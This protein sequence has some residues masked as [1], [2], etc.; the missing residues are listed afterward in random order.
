MVKKLRLKFLLASLVVFIAGGVNVQAESFNVKNDKSLRNAICNAKSND[1][2]I[3]DN[4]IT[5]KENLNIDKSVVLD[6]NQKTLVVSGDKSS[7]VIGKKEQKNKKERAMNILKLKFKEE[8]KFNYDDNI[9][10]VIKNGIISHS[11]SLRGKNGKKDSWTDFCG[12]NGG[13]P[14]ETIK[15]ESGKLALNDIQINAGNGGN[16]GNGAYQASVHFIFGGG[17]GGRGGAAGNGGD[18]IK[19]LRKTC[20]ID[21]GD[22]VVLKAGKAGKAGKDSEANPNY[23]VYKSYT[24]K[25]SA[26]AKNGQKIN[27]VF[28][29]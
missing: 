14:N 16:G 26:K 3:L 8:D 21:L 28:K 15:L 2:I 25:N 24:L 17:I 29:Q 23:W 7:I 22:N 4:N 13:S 11:N 27:K 12:K 18:A 5:L 6:L 1:T 19:I 9:N 20:S 10:I